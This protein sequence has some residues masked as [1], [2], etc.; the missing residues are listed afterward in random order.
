M[1]VGDGPG[2]N[3]LAGLVTK[4]PQHPAEERVVTG[5]DHKFLHCTSQLSG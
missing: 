1:D 2:L 4:K 3:F 5:V